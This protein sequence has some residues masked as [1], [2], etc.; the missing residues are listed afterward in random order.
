MN[1]L[2][3][4]AIISAIAIYLIIVVGILFGAI[5]EPLALKSK[6]YVAKKSDTIE[7]SLGKPTKSKQHKKSAK[8]KRKP[9]KNIA[10][11]KPKKIRN[12]KKQTKKI[13]KKV[14]KYSS[15]KITKI[16]TKKSKQN[17]SSLFKNISSNFTD[18]TLK[19]ST[20]K[21]SGKSIKKVD[22][23]KGV[24]NSYFA[25]I[26]HTLEGWPAQSNFVGEKIKVELTVYPNGLFNYKLLSS[27]LNPEFNQALKD[28]LK[29]LKRFGFGAHSNP[30]PYKII[31]EFIAKG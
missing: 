30:K 29:Q 5:Y 14:V 2:K 23:G 20:V 1:R 12:I 27:S 18:K 7:V 11:K 22:K 26:Q 8:K 3:L 28:Y 24:V 19:S 6:T 15:K 31:V 13:I 10:K 17:A 21:K 25:R 9:N 4:E 16:A